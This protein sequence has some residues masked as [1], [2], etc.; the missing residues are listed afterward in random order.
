MTLATGWASRMIGG[1]DGGQPRQRQRD[2]QVAGRLRRQPEDRQPG[3]ARQG[4]REVE[5]AADEPEEDRHGGGRCCRD[6]H[7]ASRSAEVASTTADDQEVAG[8]AAGGRE[9]EDDPERGR[10]AVRAAAHR[11]GD[12]R[13]PDDDDGQCG[14]DRTRRLLPEHGP[15]HETHDEHLEVAEDRRQPGSDG[16]D[17]VVPEQEIAGEEDAR[18]GRQPDGG[19]RQR[20]VAS[21]LED[22]DGDQDRQAEEAAEDDPGRGRHPRIPVEDPRE[23][24]AHRPKQS[25]QV[26]PSGDRL[27]RPRQP[28][29]CRLAQWETSPPIGRPGPLGFAV[30]ASAARAD[31]RIEGRARHTGRDRASTAPQA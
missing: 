1:H 21:L 20:A 27:E 8:V 28:R 31:R 26:G 24:D 23:G 10:R 18:D 7:R 3:E 30:T 12:E 14:E 29:L 11:P 17:R 9:T 25:R 4:R 2:E 13:H 15:G 6:R 19:G 16:L 22:R 5:V